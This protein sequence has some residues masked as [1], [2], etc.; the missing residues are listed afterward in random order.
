MA[1]RPVQF[2]ARFLQVRG[3]QTLYA[4]SFRSLPRNLATLRRFTSCAL[5]HTIL[6]LPTAKISPR[7][8]RFGRNDK[9]INCHPECSVAESKDPTNGVLTLPMGSFDVAQDDTWARRMTGGDTET[10]SNKKGCRKLGLR[11]P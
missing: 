6:P 5:Y 11:Q 3:I 7:R 4:L 1:Y 9:G 8:L 10:L 2:N